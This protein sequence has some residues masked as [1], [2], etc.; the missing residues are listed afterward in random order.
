MRRG[1]RSGFVQASRVNIGYGN[2]L[3]VRASKGDPEDLFAAVTRTNQA[4]TDSVIGAQRR[5]GRND[6]GRRYTGG[7]ASQL[8][9]ECSAI[10][11]DVLRG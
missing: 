7:A 4:E 9:Q 11:H 1:K 2:R 8:T 5:P 3:D 6:S 10:G